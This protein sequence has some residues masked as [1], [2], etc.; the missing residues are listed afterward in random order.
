MS[1]DL[2]NERTARIA[3]AH[4]TLPGDALTQR[5]IAGY[6]CAETVQFAL[7][8]NRPEGITDLGFESWLRGVAPHLSGTEV[9]QV[10]TKTETL[11]LTVLTP[12]NPQWQASGLT[13]LGQRAPLALWARGDTTLLAAP[14]G[15]R[16]GITGARAASFYGIHVTE[17]FTADLT[18][19]DHTIVSGA[20]YGVDGAAHRTALATGGHT[21]AVMAGGLER[22]YPAGHSELIERIGNSGLLLSEASPAHVPTRHRFEQRARLLVALTAATVITE[23]GARSG[24]LHLADEA[25]AL[26]RHIGATPGPITSAASA[27]CN[28]LIRNS[29]AALIMTAEDIRQ[30]IHDSVTRPP[31]PQRAERRASRR[32]PLPNIERIG[33][34]RPGEEPGTALGR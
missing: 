29:R 30:M 6:G 15:K 1:I 34:A 25:D 17:D 18:R 31:T 9:E 27:G 2:T 16:V 32:N 12:D 7:T 14:L 10:L 26:H 24:T 13:V 5:L 22:P 28:L 33:R 3:L 20:A 19:T 4:A 11:G 21:I 23:A 8:G